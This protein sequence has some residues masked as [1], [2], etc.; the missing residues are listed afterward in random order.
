MYKGEAA[1]NIGLG[2][3]GQS[4]TIKH[5]ST[6]VRDYDKDEY[7]PTRADVTV[8]GV[9]EDVSKSEREFLQ[10]Q[11]QLNSFKRVIIPLGTTVSIDDYFTL[12]GRTYTILQL[13]T[14]VNHI[15][16]YCR[17]EQRV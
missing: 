13:Q 6:S 12:D 10:T 4:I 14:Q 17:F 15:I 9:I 5:T 1:V 8:T 11:Y 7:K 2:L 16:L 3:A